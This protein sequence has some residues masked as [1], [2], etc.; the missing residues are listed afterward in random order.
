MSEAD[1]VASQSR[2]G[3]EFFPYAYTTAARYHLTGNLPARLVLHVGAIQ[4]DVA[5]FEV[6]PGAELLIDSIEI[7]GTR[8]RRAVE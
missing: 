4:Y 7:R 8:Y 2:P 6:K 1:R 5:I 3:W